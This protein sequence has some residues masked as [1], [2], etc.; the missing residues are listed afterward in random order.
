MSDESEEPCLLSTQSEGN[1]NS[2]K[3]NLEFESQ[4]IRKG[5]DRV[6]PGFETSENASKWKSGSP[7][8]FVQ[9]GISTSTGLRSFIC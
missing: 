5:K 3:V 6:L 1:E 4:I 2:T 8:F 7:F 9:A